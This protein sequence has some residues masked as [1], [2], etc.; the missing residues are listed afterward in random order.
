MSI[1]FQKL[2]RITAS[3]LVSIWISS[4]AT[5][6]P[7]SGYKLK[8]HGNILNN[9]FS[10]E[11]PLLI[12]PGMK[13]SSAVDIPLITIS[14][15]NPGEAIVLLFSLQFDWVADQINSD[16]RSIFGDDSEI[17]KKNSYNIYVRD[18][19]MYYHIHMV[20]E[21]ILF[22]ET[23]V[24]VNPDYWDALCKSFFPENSYEF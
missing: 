1:Q 16:Y 11:N 2:C 5:T 14:S 21:F 7:W 20:E 13:L 3:L 4:C 23:R 12:V 9:D 17:P 8:H 10:D 22:S 6:E 18:T 15:S 24:L 19:G